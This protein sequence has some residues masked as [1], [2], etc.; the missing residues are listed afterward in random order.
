MGEQGLQALTRLLS[1]AS[2]AQRVY[3]RCRTHASMLYR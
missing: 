3:E 2:R 1:R